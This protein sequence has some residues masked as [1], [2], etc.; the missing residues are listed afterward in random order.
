MSWGL[1]Q[2][3]L[4]SESNATHEIGPILPP[5]GRHKMQV[6]TS[7]SFITLPMGH[8]IGLWLA[9]PKYC[10]SSSGNIADCKGKEAP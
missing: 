1:G 8:R 9:A 10:L 4:P 6:G 2:E 7:I 3:R 5:Y